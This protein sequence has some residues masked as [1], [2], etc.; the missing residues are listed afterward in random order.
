[1]GLKHPEQ[2]AD[3]Q[4]W[5]SWRKPLSALKTALRREDPSAPV[6][7][8]ISTSGDDPRAAFILESRAA[9]SLMAVVDPLQHLTDTDVALVSS[10]DPAG[11]LPEGSWRTTAVDSFVPGRDLTSVEGIVSAAHYLPL[12]ASAHRHAVERGLAYATVQHGLLTPSAPPLPA[13][14]HLLAWSQQ[15]ADF[16]LSGRTD[17]QVTVTGSALLDRAADA[18]RERVSRFTSPLFLGQLHGAELPRVGMTRAATTFCLLTGAS[19]RPHPSETDRLSRIQ[20][21]RWRRR[22]IHIETSGVPLVQISR[23]VVSAFSTGVLEAAARGIPAWVYY[24]N[25]PGW[26]EE[27]WER[28]GLSQWGQSPTP[29]PPRPSS[30]PAASVAVWVRAHT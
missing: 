20:H 18:P 26:L 2:L 28:Y 1:M 29:P 23:P 9:S 17:I 10:F 11:I 6:R 27:F 3:W 19:Y 8:W 5:Q 24:P 15:D 16:W 7:A 12:G 4:R 25:P 14:T 21:A 22:G 13:G 30:D